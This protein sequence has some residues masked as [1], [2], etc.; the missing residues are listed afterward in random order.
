[1]KLVSYLA[2]NLFWFY[3]AVR[4]FIGRTLEIETELLQSAVDPLA[5]PDLLADRLD[6]AFVCGLP[7][8]RHHQVAPEQLRAIVA[9]IM[10]LPRYENQPI[11]FSDVIVHSASLFQSINDLVGTAFCYNDLGSN[12]GYHLLRH[13][14]MANHYPNHYFRQTIQSGSHQQS[15]RWVATGKADCAA[16]DST[17]LEQEWQHSP[18]LKPQLR[19]VQAIGPC[20]MPP[21][22]AAQHLGDEL[23]AAL[24]MALLQPDAELQIAMQQANISRF[25]AVRS[26]SYQAIAALYDAITQCGYNL[27][28]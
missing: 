27:A 21:L 18:E 19:V 4:A 16:I 28:E 7:F 8:I 10:R 13:Y 9:P 20:P 12:S 6:L 23:I 11:Y 24:Q 2:P 5:D 22:V 15:I 17:V 26:E 25:A 3:E 1:M 14:L